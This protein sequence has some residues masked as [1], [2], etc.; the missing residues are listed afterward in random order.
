ML[1]VTLI[2]LPN[3]A[4]SQGRLVALDKDQSLHF[5]ARR[6]YVIYDTPMDATRGGHATSSNCALVVLSGRVA[7][8]LDNSEEVMTIQLSRPDQALRIDAGVW[9]RL[10]NFAEGT[11]VLVA[12]S[13][14]YVES[15]Y[16]E[17]P[18]SQLLKND[19]AQGEAVMPL[20]AP[21]IP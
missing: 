11:I 15:V 8:D 9:L 4:G 20:C 19:S 14:T 6:V 18:Q 17:Q 2:E 10:H 7:V 12:A 21:R 16:F 3:H 5:D 13:Q 1:G